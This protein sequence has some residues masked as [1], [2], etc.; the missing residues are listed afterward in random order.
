MFLDDAES[1]ETAARQSAE[2]LTDG[3]TT[4]RKAP[5]VLICVSSGRLVAHCSVLLFLAKS[6]AQPPVAAEREPGSVVPPLP[7]GQA[8][9][10]FSPLVTESSSCIELPLVLYP[11]AQ[12]N[13]V[14]DL[15]HG[16]SRC[17]LTV[18]VLT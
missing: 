8:R 6:A 4:W 13:A 2:A 17:A 11:A 16:D 5:Y 9:K 12:V 15:V 10:F 18:E 3:H 1:G 14:L 7:K